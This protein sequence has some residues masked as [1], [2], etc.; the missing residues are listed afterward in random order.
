MCEGQL[1]LCEREPILT[2]KN[3]N[4]FLRDSFLVYFHIC[5]WGLHLNMHMKLYVLTFGYMITFC[6]VTFFASWKAAGGPLNCLNV[7][8]KLKYIVVNASSFTLKTISH[9]CPHHCEMNRF[10]ID[11]CLVCVCVCVKQALISSLMQKSL[12]EALYQLYICIKISK[13]IWGCQVVFNSNGCQQL[14]FLARIQS[15]C[16]R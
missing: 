10:Q 11:L 2:N 1:V 13:L 16:R 12:T 6:N 9:S 8:V 7:M 15:K 3:T 4:A 5:R 14:L